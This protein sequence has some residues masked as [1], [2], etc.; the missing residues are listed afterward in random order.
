MYIITAL[1]IVA[2]QGQ[3]RQG[4]RQGG[5]RQGRQ[6]EGADA[7][8]GAPQAEY[9]VQADASSL[10]E[11]HEGGHEG[12]D[13]LLNSVPGTPGE[14]YPILAEVPETAFSCD[15]QVEGGKIRG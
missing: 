5:R 13:W 12:L 9:G 14:D 3:R 7:G 6:E 8:Y 15:G 1:A 10:S 4:R 11:S 2:V